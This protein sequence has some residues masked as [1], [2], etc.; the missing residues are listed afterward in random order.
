M[1]RKGGGD[2]AVQTCSYKVSHGNVIMHNPG[3]VG[4]NTIITVYGGR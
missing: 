2:S 4:S 3:D 1:G